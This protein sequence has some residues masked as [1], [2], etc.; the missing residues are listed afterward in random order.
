MT[1]ARSANVFIAPFIHW[2][3]ILVFESWSPIIANHDIDYDCHSQRMR[4]VATTYKHVTSNLLVRV[5]HYIIIVP[6]FKCIISCQRLLAGMPYWLGN[7]QIPPSPPENDKGH[8]P[9]G[10]NIWNVSFKKS[11]KD[12]NEKNFKTSTVI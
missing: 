1:Y 6:L 11:G 9:V 12:S 5:F 4:T 7:C 8:R 2:L 10:R 3:S